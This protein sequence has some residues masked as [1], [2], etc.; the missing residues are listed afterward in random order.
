MA[1][2]AVTPTAR[3]GGV[4]RSGVSL[5][6]TPWGGRGCPPRPAV[7]IFACSRAFPACNCRLEDG[8]P[9]VAGALLSPPCSHRSA[10]DCCSLSPFPMRPRRDT[11]LVCLARIFLESKKRASDGNNGRAQGVPGRTGR[12]RGRRPRQGPRRGQELEHGL[13]EGRSAEAG[14]RPCWGESSCRA[15]LLCSPAEP[16]SSKPMSQTP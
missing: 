14:R 16:G 3:G 9:G 8:G 11:R 6:I 7:P 10:G 13:L 12:A 4:A 2:R 15:T 1:P 5:R